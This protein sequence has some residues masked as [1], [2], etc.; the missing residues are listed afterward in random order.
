MSEPKTPTWKRALDKVL[1]TVKTAKDLGLGSAVARSIP[2]DPTALPVAPLFEPGLPSDVADQRALA[3]WVP[4]RATWN[5]Q[6][7]ANAEHA[8]AWDNPERA[9]YFEKKRTRTRQTPL[10]GLE[11]ILNKLAM[12]S[13]ARKRKGVPGL[14]HSPQY[15]PAERERFRDL[16]QDPMKKAAFGQLVQERAGQVEDWSGQPPSIFPRPTPPKNQK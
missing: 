7:R 2:Q 1:G 16:I 4:E 6:L 5:R 3:P 14:K 12:A 9:E 11:S 8:R 10:T 15:K 13:G